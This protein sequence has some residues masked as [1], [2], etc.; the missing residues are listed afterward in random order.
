MLDLEGEVHR[1]GSS[2]LVIGSRLSQLR[3]TSRIGIRRCDASHPGVPVD[4]QS[5][6]RRGVVRRRRVVGVEEQHAFEVDL[7]DPVPLQDDRLRRRLDRSATSAGVGR[8]TVVAAHDLD[9]F[10]PRRTAE[11]AHP[12]GDPPPATA[13]DQLIAL[14]RGRQGPDQQTENHD[15]GQHQFLARHLLFLL[16][17]GA[18]GRDRRPPFRLHF[19]P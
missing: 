5:E 16:C 3:Q 11:D 7:V 8:P 9:R 14:S 13:V 19:T 12:V 6:L 10:G 15:S 18:V 1:T 2:P 4:Q 17:S